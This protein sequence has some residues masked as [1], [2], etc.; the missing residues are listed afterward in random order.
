MQQSLGGVRWETK[1]SRSPQLH[2]KFE[3]CLGYVKSC[4][5]KQYKNNKT[6]STPSPKQKY[7]ASSVPVPTTTL[8]VCL[9]GMVS[10]TSTTSPIFLAWECSLATRSCGLG[11]F[12]KQGKSFKESVPSVSRP[13]AKV[14]VIGGY[15]PSPLRNENN[16]LSTLDA[17]TWLG[18]Y[19]TAHSLC[20]LCWS[21]L[22]VLCASQI[23]RCYP[24]PCSQI[25]DSE[26]DTQWADT[27]PEHWLSKNLRPC[28][29]PCRSLYYTPAGTFLISSSHARAESV[30]ANALQEIASLCVC[31]CWHLPLR[32][33][34]RSI[35]SLE[36]ALLKRGN[37]WAD[38]ISERHGTY[39][40]RWSCKSQ[41]LRDSS[42]GK[43][44]CLSVLCVTLDWHYAIMS[45][46]RNGGQ[47]S[48]WWVTKH[49][50]IHVSSKNGIIVSLLFLPCQLLL[51]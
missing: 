51:Q 26:S 33:L 3:A 28:P 50:D 40:W 6:T 22:P 4:F 49:L 29:N 1:G 17:K 14:H 42:P 7:T 35:I 18:S 27:R 2:S 20:I 23:P 21:S 12:Q 47:E 38:S 48:L 19:R 11:Q 44:C 31:F 32:H 36:R 46:Y 5:K 24:T 45:H 15:I 37:E 9:F 39:E 16:L 41:R 34:Q 43:R 10:S 25:L 13:Q 8:N 30:R